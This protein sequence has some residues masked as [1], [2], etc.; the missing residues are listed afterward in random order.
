MLV[1]ND[2]TPADVLFGGE[3]RR[4]TVPRDYAVQPTGD[5][6]VVPQFVAQPVGDL[7]PPSQIV[8]IPES[9]WIPRIQER[10]ARNLGLSQ[11]RNT[12]G[13]NGGRMPAKDQNGQ[14]YCWAYSVSRAMEFLIVKANQPYTPLSAHSVACKIKGFA[15]EGGWCG[16]SAKFIAENGVVPESRWPAKSMSRSLDNSANWEAARRYRMIEGFYDLNRQVWDQKI[17]W[18]AIVTLLLSNIPVPADFAWWG[19]SV[20]LFDLDV[21]DGEVCPLLDNS[22]TDGWGTNGVGALQGERKYPMGAVA[23]L[24]VVAV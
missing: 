21:I 24:A 22:W 5:G 17:A 20:C 11:I 9:E 12:C 10:K 1:I 13:P 15:D 14:G 19:H 2:S 4:G 7:T 16:L 8:L 18:A 6:L 23:P 3:T